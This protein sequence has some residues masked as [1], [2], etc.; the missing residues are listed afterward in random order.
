MVRS[1]KHINLLELQAFVKEEKR[2]CEAYHGIRI[3][4]GIDSQVCLGTV[5]KGRASSKPLNDI[6]RRSMAFALKADNYRFFM[7]YP[8]ENNRADGPTR[9]HE[10]DPPDMAQPVWISEVEKGN[11]CHNMMRGCTPTADTS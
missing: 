7:Y 10:P 9:D 6:L 3:P 1:S 4:V 11:Y 2:I 8:S 5:V